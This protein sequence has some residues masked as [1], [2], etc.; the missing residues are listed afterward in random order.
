LPTSVEPVNATLS[1]S[2]WPTTAPGRAR[3]GDDVDDAG[4]QVGLLAD[5]GEEQR[6]Q[7]R[8]LGRLED[9]GVAG[10]ERR[11]RSSTRA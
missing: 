1:T 10:G 6:G 2:A 4:R 3:A 7:R 11:A 5:L 8:R 9:D